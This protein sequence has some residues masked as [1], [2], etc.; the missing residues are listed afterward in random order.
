[1]GPGA[2]ESETDAGPR[3]HPAARELVVAYDL[4]CT[5]PAAVAALRELARTAPGDQDEGDGRT[6]P[7]P[8]G[9]LRSFVE[10]VTARGAL[11]GARGTRGSP[12][13]WM[14]RFWN[15]L[16]LIMPGQ[17]GQV[18]GLASGGSSSSL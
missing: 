15:L 17:R 14:K 12:P 13:T 11:G 8:D 3:G 2:G 7:D 9:N 6:P 5:D 4:T 10:A 18:S 1:V 16:A